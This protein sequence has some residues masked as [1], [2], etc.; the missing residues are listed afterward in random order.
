MAYSYRINVLEDLNKR[1]V[2]VAVSHDGNEGVMSCSCADGISKG[3]FDAALN[4]ADFRDHL[5]SNSG[6]TSRVDGQIRQF[7]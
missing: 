1:Q 6:S 2:V 5:I 4:N 3:L 7:G